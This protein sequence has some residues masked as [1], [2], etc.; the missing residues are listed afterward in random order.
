MSYAASFKDKNNVEHPVTSALY[1]TCSTAAATAAKEV[2]CSN[3]DAL[4]AGMTIRVVFTNAN[5]A[6]S[7]TININSKGAKN[8]YRFGTTTPVGDGSWEAGAVVDLFYDG[9][10]FFMI[11]SQ[12]VEAIRTSLAA[13]Q[14]STDNNLATTSKQVVGAI[15][16]VNSNFISLGLSVVNGKLCQ[17]Y[18]V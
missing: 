13:K 5:T 14:N 18:T 3:V 8:V 9:T 10:S 12:D 16:E 15:N 6:D 17:T 2:V 4:T 11:G 7:P 1:G